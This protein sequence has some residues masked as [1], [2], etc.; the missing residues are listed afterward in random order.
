MLLPSLPPPWHLSWIS[1]DRASPMYR[2][3]TF[4]RRLARQPPDRLS[5]RPIGRYGFGPD[6][7]PRNWA[8]S[9]ACA[10]LRDLTTK[11]AMYLLSRRATFFGAEASE[12]CVVS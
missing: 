5:R 11:R 1:L 9:I 2:S 8:Y 7:T 6:L 4:Q 10:A 12:P 3:Q